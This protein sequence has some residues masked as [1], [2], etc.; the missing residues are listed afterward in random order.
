MQLPKYIGETRR[1]EA[2]GRTFVIRRIRSNTYTLAAL[3]LDRIRF[4]NRKEILQDIGTAQATGQL[5][6]QQ[7][8]IPDAKH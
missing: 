1:F 5:P 6:K 3:D 8:S 2:Y 7:T 4:G